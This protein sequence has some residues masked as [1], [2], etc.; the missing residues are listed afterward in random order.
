MSESK[1]T[2]ECMNDYYY[3]EG[4]IAYIVMQ[5]VSLCLVVASE[6]GSTAIVGPSS[7]RIL[8]HTV[9]VSLI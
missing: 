1:N 5:F 3:W 9:L 6:S 8:S 2:W 7:R 4:K